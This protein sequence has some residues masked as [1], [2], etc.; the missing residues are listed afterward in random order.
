MNTTSVTEHYNE[1][2]ETALKDLNL[3]V[4]PNGLY[5]PIR[6][7]L[8][9]GG[10]RMRPLLALLSAAQFTDDVAKALPV[11]LA[12]EVF[13]NFSLLHDDVMDNAPLRRGKAT[14]HEKWDINTAIL[15]GDGM[16]IIAYKCLEKLSGKNLIPILNLF[17]Q[18]ALE[19]CEGQQYDVEFATQEKVQ[20]DEYI[21]MIRLKTA[22][23]PAFCMQA[24]A[25]ACNVEDDEVEKLRVIGETLGIAFQLMDDFLDVYG[26]PETF[27]KQVGGDILENKKTYLYLYALETAEG[28]DLDALKQW[29]S[30]SA[31]HNPEEKIN[32]VTKLYTKLGVKTAT[33]SLIQKYSELASDL[34]STLPSS[35]EKKEL[36]LN[37]T[38][39]LQ[40][41]IQ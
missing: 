22:V 2:I 12:A 9:L 21:E 19:V 5:E 34:I 30:T 37:Y 31:K 13:H 1:I 17:N 33:Q 36:L 26:N 35:S 29:F 20:L 7:I 14:V 39:L 38:S 6:Y 8:S 32:T 28:D 40:H 3:P 16:L 4:A 10:K 27:G 15:S 23:L 41:R 25:I 11:G 24:A 18:C